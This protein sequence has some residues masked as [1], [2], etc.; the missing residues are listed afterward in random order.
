M[1]T[2]TLRNEQ[3]KNIR[4]AMLKTLDTYGLPYSFV[5]STDAQIGPNTWFKITVDNQTT[6]TSS[7][8]LIKVSTLDEL[9]THTHPLGGV[10]Q[11]MH[12]NLRAVVDKTIS[13]VDKFFA[14]T[15]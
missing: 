2:V 12:D 10:E 9:D 13:S 3:I 11:F 5:V 6:K 8:L 7:Y 15:Q 1:T 14:E 4:K